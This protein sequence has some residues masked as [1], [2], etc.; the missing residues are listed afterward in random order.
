MH[1]LHIINALA[2]G[3]A[4]R[5]LV[6]FLPIMQRMGNTVKVA[7]LQGGGDLEQPMRES[8]IDVV[9]LN[10]PGGR[11]NPLAVKRLGE[12]VRTADVVHSHLFPSQ[13]WA[14]FAYKFYGKKGSVLVTTEHN[15][16]NTRGRH[17][18]S[19]LIDNGIYG[20]YDGVI[21]IS[22]GTKNFMEKRTPCSV[23]LRVIENG[24][25]LPTVTDGTVLR[26]ERAS[27]M[28]GL[29]ENDFALLQVA[30]F[31]EQKNQA[32]VLRALQQLPENVHAVFAG[33]GVT[34]DAHRALAEKLGIGHRA[35]FLGLRNDVDRLWQA[36]DM[37]VMS[38]Q[39]EGFGLAAVEG[40]A[41]RRVVLASDVSGLSE[42]VNAPEL[43]FAP[44]NDAELAKKIAYFMT[45]PEERH[46][47]EKR[48]HKRA[49]QFSVEKMTQRYL[50]FYEELL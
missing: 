46:E 22:E 15:T 14:A 10:L 27:L 25:A 1:I 43:L 7:L 31:T 18:I 33:Y 49:Q 28:D 17:W 2:V 4:E 41:R 23:K 30:R 6:S 3:G 36:A 29:G 35:H 50:D 16:F 40:M 21:C 24:V 5:L 12:F 44:D 8:G 32:C 20:M 9:T 26:K 13:Y 47:W 34:L 11:Y 37:G 45:H 39:W 42:V 48:C 38:S 19:T